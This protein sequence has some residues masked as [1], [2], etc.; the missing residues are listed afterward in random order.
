MIKL[1]YPYLIQGSVAQACTKKLE[2]YSV[3][4][5][6]PFKLLSLAANALKESLATTR[7]KSRIFFRNMELKNTQKILPK[8]EGVPLQ[9]KIL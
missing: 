1:T 8:T 2:T 7:E 4:K 3:V 9:I 5:K 6:E